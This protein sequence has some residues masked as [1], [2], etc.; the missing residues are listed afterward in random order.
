MTRL[1]KLLVFALFFAFSACSQ[2]PGSLPETAATPTFTPYIAGTETALALSNTIATL[3]FTP[4]IAGTETALALSNSIDTSNTP[5]ALPTIPF[6]TAIP[7]SP[8]PEGTFSPVLYGGNSDTFLL[9]GGFKKDQG[10]LSGIDASHYVDPEANYDFFSPNESI[11]VRGNVLEISPTCRNYYMRSSI[12][13]SEPMVG[14]VSGWIAGKRGTKDLSTDD[15]A[16]IQAVT[17]WFHSQGNS[18]T[19]IQITRTLQVD[20]EGDGVD[21]VLLSASYVK[22]SSGQRTQTGD[23]SVVLLRKVQE[24]NVLTIPLVKDYYISSDPEIEISYP[25]FYAPAE[26]VDLNGDGTLEVVVSVRG[27]FSWGAIVY[28]VDGQ[29]VREVLRAMAIC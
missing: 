25:K 12:D 3:T 28:R 18:P 13:M 8:L 14:V 2:K 26:A 29:N 10:W 7:F 4:Y 23:Y 5:I 16:Y 19:K 24:N 11:Q 9:L 20:I 21:E 15:P 17:E 27:L 1:Q 6:P 22:D